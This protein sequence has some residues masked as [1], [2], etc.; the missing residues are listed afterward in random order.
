MSRLRRLAAACALLATA[1]APAVP[2]VPALPLHVGGRTVARAD[3]ARLYGWPGTYFESRFSG[4]A[5]RVRFDAPTDNL[6]LSIDGTERQVFHDPGPVDQVVGGLPDGAHTV[7]LELMTESYHAPGAFL[8]FYPAA[9]SAARPAPRYARQIEFIGDS[10][11]V[12]FGNLSPSR[13]CDVR[14]EH[15]RTDTSATYAAIAA[16]HYGADYRIHAKSGFGMLRNYGGSNPGMN[17]PAVYDRAV[18]GEAAPVLGTARSS[19]WHPQVVVIN[20]GTNDFSTPVH[21]GETWPDAARFAEAYRQQYEAFARRVAR[22]QPQARIV[23][24]GAANFY[25]QV[26]QVA[27]AIDPGRRR[28]TTAMFAAP[29]NSGC[30]FHPSRGDHW[31]MSRTLMDAVDA[32]GPIWPRERAPGR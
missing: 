15:D 26:E 17:L 10:I 30:K 31:L 20:L 28:F 9:G 13:T 22:D 2:D 18:G 5:V 7:R 21:A 11:T 4:T 24:L 29:E 6:R 1:T 32:L 3:G 19:D 23:L 14:Q 12:G 25:A 16:R 27:R 8:G